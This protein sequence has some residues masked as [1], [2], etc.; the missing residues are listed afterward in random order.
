V[1]AFQLDLTGELHRYND[2]I[3]AELAPWC[4]GPILEVGAGTGTF[5]RRLARAGSRVTAVEPDPTLA[6]ALRQGVAACPQ[7]VVHEGTA[8]TL[9]DAAV[10]AGGFQTAVS[11]NVL[12]HIEDDLEALRV[13]RGLLGR[14]GTVC[15]LVPGSPWAYNRIDAAMG[16]HRRYTPAGLQELL[17]AAG[18][19][20][21]RACWFNKPGAVAWWWTGRRR[22]DIP[23]ASARLYD[24]LVP[25]LRILDPILPLP[26]GQSVLA[27]AWR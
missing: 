5:T 15:L 16:H 17:A 3:E 19:E 11:L 12:E 8:A 24:R 4:R 21:P 13:I 27:T 1:T 18:Y 9:P 14:G 10:P 23:P 26:C 20:N 6:R 25:L 7:V 2:W 22:A